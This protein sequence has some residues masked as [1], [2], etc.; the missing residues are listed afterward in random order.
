[1]TDHFSTARRLGFVLVVVTIATVGLAAIGSAQTAEYS[2]NE[3]VSLTNDTEPIT[4]SV[5]WNE[6]ASA[7]T[8]NVTFE[9]ETAANNT[10]DVTNDLASSTL[11][12]TILNL[13]TVYPEGTYTATLNQSEAGTVSVDPSA[14]DAS[15]TIDLS[16]QTSG[17]LTTDD[18]I[19]S[20]SF[21]A[22]TLLSDSLTADAGN[23]TEAEYNQSD[24]DLDPGNKY[25]VTVTGPSSAID[26]AS[27]DDSSGLFG[28][29]LAGSSDLGGGGVLV[30][31]GV[32]GA[33][34]IGAAVFT[35]RD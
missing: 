28:G 18:T 9:N 12:G 32:I 17:N 33:A 10:G 14:F 7:E 6:S 22:D 13:S 21:S 16:T 35:M 3:T 19:N 20:L 25:R 15:G 23:T 1:M 11:N 5:D 27:I 34:V 8:A 4:V 31:L 29:V 26:S 24:A 30:G 2:T